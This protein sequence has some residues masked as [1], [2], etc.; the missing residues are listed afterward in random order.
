[1]V[2]WFKEV[3]ATPPER[4]KARLNIHAN[5]NDKKIKKYWSKITDISLNRFGKSYIKPE[6]TGH[7][8][9]ILHNGVIGVGVGNED[10][11]HKIMAWIKA[12]YQ[13]L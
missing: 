6:G 13:Q 1:M 2:R 5:Q 4:L 10:L 9:N 12:L 8:K 11:R 3:C 7:R